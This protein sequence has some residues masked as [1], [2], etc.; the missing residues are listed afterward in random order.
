MT[1]LG[2][3]VTAAALDGLPGGSTATTLMLDLP[4]GLPAEPFTCVMLNWNPRGHQPTA[5][6]GKPH[7]DIHFD[8]VTMSDLQAISPSSPGFAAKAAHLPDAA[9]TPQGFAPLPGPPLAAQAVPGMGLHLADAGS[10]PTPG[11]Y[12]FQHILLAGSWDGRYTFIEPMIA[13]DWLLARRPYAESVHQPVAY[14]HDGRYPLRYSS[15]FDSGDD[16][17]RVELSDFVTRRAS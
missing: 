17:Y 13:R 5:L 9:H 6:F 12:N 10:R 8:M 1:G 16:T 11:H 2:V 15:R 4:S 7:F 14:Q 3:A